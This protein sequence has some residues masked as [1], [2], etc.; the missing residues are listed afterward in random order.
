ML[1]E[2]PV[3]IAWLSSSETVLELADEVTLDAVSVV[4]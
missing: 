1:V 2:V 4:P 3:G